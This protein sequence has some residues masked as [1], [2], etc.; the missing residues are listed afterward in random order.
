[1]AEICIE[2][3][4]QSAENRAGNIIMLCKQSIKTYDNLIDLSKKV[5]KMIRGKTN[6]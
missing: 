6:D 1:M 2:E 5:Q 3:L 4:A